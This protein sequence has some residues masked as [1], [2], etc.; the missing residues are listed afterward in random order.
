MN[1]LE[2]LTRL[3]NTLEQGGLPQNDID[4]AL[5][6]YEE[7]FLD[8]GFG[9]DEE[10][11]QSLGSPEEIANGILADSG[12]HTEGDA[13]FL[14]EKPEQSTQGFEN[15]ST[16]N[17]YSYGNGTYDGAQGSYSYDANRQDNTYASS[18]GMSTAAKVIIIILTFP[19]WVGIAAALFGLTVA[20]IAAAFALTV[21]FAASGIA[22][23]AYGMAMLIKVPPVGLCMLGAGFILTGIF[24]L[25]LRPA[26][27]GLN[28][29]VIGGAK[30]LV[31][32]I[33]DH[34][35]R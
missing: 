16:A 14:P 17:S 15:S 13:E 21:A 11:S 20:L 8:A 19:L 23:I 22:L 30:K 6:Y 7:V 25:I 31:S 35:N 18:G 33:R 3:R 4:D 26:F 10:T 12:I 1:R 9:K 24:G 5:T 28:K 34:F 2:F 29:Y 27:K 32:W